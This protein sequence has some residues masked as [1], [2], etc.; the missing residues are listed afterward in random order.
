M[1]ELSDLCNNYQ[2]LKKTPAPWNHL[3]GCYETVITNISNIFVHIV[4]CTSDY[5]R[6]VDWQLD[7]L[8]SLIQ[9]VTTLYNSLLHIHYWSQ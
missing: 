1:R 5:R 6:D 2:L 9:R 3:I 8:D 4:T 7:S